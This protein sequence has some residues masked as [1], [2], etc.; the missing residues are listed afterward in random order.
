M[1]AKSKSVG[2]RYV[3]IERGLVPRW[4]GWPFPGEV[5]DLRSRRTKKRRR[6]RRISGT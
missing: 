1:R 3:A 2:G 6:A 4:S 5:P